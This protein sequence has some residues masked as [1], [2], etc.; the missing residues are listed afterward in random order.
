MTDR[1]GLELVCWVVNWKNSDVG[2][3]FFFG[4]RDPHIAGVMFRGGFRPLARL[5][6]L[7]SELS[8]VYT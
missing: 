4:R 2:L 8:V 3:Y 7:G 5:K 6:C 1:G